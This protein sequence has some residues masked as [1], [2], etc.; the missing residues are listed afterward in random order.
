MT[1]SNQIK[2]N[3]RDDVVLLN[4]S[5]P[6][7]RIRVELHLLGG[8]GLMQENQPGVTFKGKLLGRLSGRRGIH[9]QTADS[10]APYCANSEGKGQWNC[11][12]NWHDSSLPPSAFSLHIVSTGS[13]GNFHPFAPLDCTCLS[14]G[15]SIIYGLNLPASSSNPLTIPI[16]ICRTTWPSRQTKE[17]QTRGRT[18]VTRQDL[19]TRLNF[20]WVHTP[21]DI[22]EKF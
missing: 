2:C 12:H 5:I 11:S 7:H 3:V 10:G 15:Q 21:S 14:L 16:P 18:E 13:T 17:T 22:I 20:S 4:P 8:E 9:S 19:A 6:C 1:R